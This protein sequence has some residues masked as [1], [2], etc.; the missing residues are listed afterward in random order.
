[1]EQQVLQLLQA[2][3]IPDT[4]TI[5]RAEQSLR[6]LYRQP[7]Y[8]FAL[9]HITTHSEI[10]GGLRKAALTALRNYINATWS[11]TFEESTSQGLFLTDEARTQVRSQI[12]AICTSPSASN[13]INQN[14]AGMSRGLTI[15]I[16]R[17]NFA[18]HCRD[19]ANANVIH[20]RALSQRLHL[21]TFQ[22]T[23]L[24]SFLISSV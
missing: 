24:N 21:P 19:R 23:G 9:L 4:N 17:M 16:D 12:L 6:D 1:M 8:P 15:T 10:D 7:D 11:P 22:T 20:Q 14:L 18:S 3:T 13:D 2:T 5:K